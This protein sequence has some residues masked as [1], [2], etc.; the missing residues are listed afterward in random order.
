M[1][2]YVSISLDPIV[3]RRCRLRQLPVGTVI[4]RVMTTFGT[5]M[6]AGFYSPD[7]HPC[8]YRRKGRGKTGLKTDVTKLRIDSAL[9]AA[10]KARGIN[11]SAAIRYAL[12][13]Y[14]TLYS[15]R[16]GKD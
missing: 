8:L 14:S 12:Q 6:D 13:E 15:E 9:H 7:S 11:L 2:D 5:M 1:S 10:I 3:R 4:N 16:W